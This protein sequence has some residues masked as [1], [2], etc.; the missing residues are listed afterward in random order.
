MDHAVMSGTALASAVWAESR[1]PLPLPG[2]AG[3]SRR[4][5]ALAALGARD[6]CLAKLVE[7]HHDAIAILSDL[8]GDTPTPDSL[9]AVWAA[10]PPSARLRAIP[11]AG[12]WRLSG[13][14]AF[15]SGA[16]IVTHALVTAW[17]D[18][19][20]WLFAIDVAAAS[21]SG[22]IE[23]AEPDWVGDG[24]RRAGTRTLV[25]DGL[26]ARSVGGSGD[27][28]ARPGFWHGGVGVAA[29]WLGGARA[30]GAVL[31]RATREREPGPH[32]T[33]HLGAVT[34]V[35]DSATAH[36]HAAAA[37]IDAD[38]HDER[39]DA[40]RTTQSVRATIAS[41][42]DEV[43]GRTARALGPGPLAFEA[44][45]AQRVTDLHVFVRQHHAERDLADLGRIVAAK[46]PEAST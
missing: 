43:V 24:M 13:R 34:A 8:H 42:A 14:K 25:I 36:L 9:W 18:E 15:C 11:H 33:A 23:L 12:A 20:P 39:G 31:L 1:R 3:T 44:A 35:L 5:E 29:C 22:A 37:Q 40:R 19:E 41:A 4:F 45:H 17:A 26:D 6:L 10:E 7:S 32:A 38:P 46:E 27:Y 2:S 16:A 28:V 30:V 21:A